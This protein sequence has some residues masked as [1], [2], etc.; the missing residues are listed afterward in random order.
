M[1]VQQLGL[2][3]NKKTDKLEKLTKR[4]F[5][6]LNLIYFHWFEFVQ[7]KLSV[8]VFIISMLSSWLQ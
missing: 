5:Q 3:S 7:Q 4:E 6:R 1:V 8:F 2:H